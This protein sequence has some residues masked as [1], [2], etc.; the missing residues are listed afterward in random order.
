[1]KI[2]KK[3]KNMSNEIEYEDFSKINL[4]VGEI[5]SADNIDGA[6]KLLKLTVNLGELGDKE[7]FAGIKK[8]YKADDLVGLK[9]L[10]VENLKP[11]KMKFGTSSGMVLAA[12]S[13]GDIIVIEASSKIKKWVESK[14]NLRSVALI[15]E[16]KL[17]WL[18]DLYRRMSI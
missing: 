5:I 16:N 8:F 11:K 4:R 18:R 10:V 14:M 2:K 15:D 9:T 1:M 17:Y 3:V 7:I 13:D 12:D 6:D